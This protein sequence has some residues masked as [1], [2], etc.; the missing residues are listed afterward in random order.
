MKPS[1]LIYLV[2][3]LCLGLMTS[4]VFAQDAPA[5]TKDAPTATKDAPT[6]TKDAPAAP[7]DAP[8]VEDL[9]KPPAEAVKADHAYDSKKALTRA[10]VVGFMNKDVDVIANG[11]FSYEA[12][13]KA[14]PAVEDK[15]AIITAIAKDAPDKD[16]AKQEEMAQG[17][18]EYVKKS[19]SAEGRKTSALKELE[20]CK[21]FDFSKA[22][23]TEV[24]GGEPAKDPLLD[25]L[26]PTN[27]AFEH[28]KVGFE[29][30]AKKATI[31]FRTPAVLGGNFGVL[32][33]IRCRMEDVSPD[34]PMNSK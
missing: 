13:V 10:I 31:K 27:K 32:G 9:T 19:F 14:C 22:K 28:I 23:P 16:P 25:T 8:T 2:L 3:I 24:S 34:G 17:F 11:A 6:A 33:G 20:N 29:D 7:T 30:G 5:A 15:A 12:L 18:Q 4:V 1:R 21:G 26:C